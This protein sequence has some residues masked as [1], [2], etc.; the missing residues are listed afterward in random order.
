VPDILAFANQLGFANIPTTIDPLIQGSVLS[1]LPT[2]SNAAGGDGLNTA[3][4]A[5]NRHQDQTRNTYSSRFDVDINDR[6]SISAIYNHNLES[7]LRPDADN[8]KF[9]VVPGVIQFSKND[10]VTFAWRRTINNSLINEVRGGRFHSDVPFNR[11][12]D[13]PSAFLLVNASGLIAPTATAAGFVSYPVNNFL[14]QGRQAWGNNLQDNVDWIKGK[15]SFKFGGQLQ[16]FG[17]DSYNDAGIVPTYV[18][19]TGSATPQFTTTSGAFLP[20]GAGQTSTISATQLATANSLMALLGGVISGGTRSFNAASVSAGFQPVRQFQPFRYKN[21]SLYFQDRWQLAQRLTLT[22]GL[23]YELFPALTLDNGLAVEPVITDPANPLASVLDRNGSYRLLGGNAGKENAYYKTDKNNLAPTVGFAYAL[24]SEKG[25]R[26]LLFGSQGKSVLRGGY[27]HVYGNDSIVT[28]INNAAAG[29]VGLGRTTPNAVN[30]A[31]GTASLNDRLSGNLTQV[32]A[33]AAFV[34]PRSYLFNNSAAV[35]GNFGTVFAVDPQIQIP[36]IKQYSLG[37]QREFGSTA[38]EIRYVGTSS[39]NLARSIDFNQIDIFNNGFLADFRRAAANR[40]LT[41]NAFCATAGCQTLSMFQNGGTGSAGHLAV[42]TGVTLATFN[43]NLDGGTPAD[44]ALLFIQNNLNNHPT[45]ANP[46]ATPFVPL[47]ANPATG[48]AN[49]FT[50][51]G[52]YNYNSLQVEVRRRLSKGLYL[53]GNY[54]FSKNLTNAVGTTQQLVEPFLDNNN[55]QWDKQR[56]DFDLTHVFNFNAIYAFPFGKGKQFLNQGGLLDRVV[57]GWEL[58]SIVGWT[59]GPP[60]TFVDTRG[61]FNR[62]GRSARQTANTN[63]T[64]DQVRALMGIFKTP[65]GIYYINPSVINPATGRAAEGFGTTPF[66]GQAFFNVNPGQTGNMSR[67]VIDGPGYFNIDAAMLKNIRIKESMRLQLRFEAF[68]MLNH[69]NFLP[70]AAGQFT[71]ITS[72]TFGQITR[73]LAGR[74]MQFAAR[75][76]F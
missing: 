8:T 32:A 4:F 12:D 10:Q 76:E 68:N 62:S 37:F 53:Q 20:A 74:E 66:A 31:T 56:A 18:N 51:G 3:G 50:N 40:A 48:V 23:R 49:L 16:Y 26:H 35:G 65:N 19:T 1:Q 54:T 33:P 9:T 36:R 45:V 34:S 43:N 52:T 11:T 15:H 22:L 61:T 21:H 13:T 47:V 60:I 24:G 39:N 27:G 6:N 70:P 71:S 29:N 25:W 64:N 17:V 57:G 44:L 59:S 73:T 63:L 2:V 67:A 69:A 7:N 28:S 58:S 42:G 41:G 38:F 14:S 46:T 5:L 30:P 75:F 55:K 72:S